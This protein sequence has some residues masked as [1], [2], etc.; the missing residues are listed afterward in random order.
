VFLVGPEKGMVPRI[1]LLQN[2]SEKPEA[3]AGCPESSTVS[4][5]SY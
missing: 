5:L 3:T 2:D 1:V 4:D